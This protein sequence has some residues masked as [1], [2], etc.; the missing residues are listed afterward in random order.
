MRTLGL[1][2]GLAALVLAASVAPAA[3]GPAPEEGTAPP[4]GQPPGPPPGPQGGP[5]P[6]EGGWRPFRGSS[7]FRD[8][9][10]KEIEEILAFTA[11]HLPPVHA[12]LKKARESDPDRFRQMCRRLRFEIR[13][14]QGLRSWN[15]EAFRKAIEERLLETHIRELA[16]TYRKTDNAADRERLKR[17]LREA[18]QKRFEAELI[19]RRAQ[20]QHLE[21]ALKHIRQ[22]LADRE[23]RREEFIDRQLEETSNPPPKAE[24]PERGPG[25]RHERPPPPEGAKP[26]PPPEGGK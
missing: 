5:P 20:V 9:T 1:A 7:M 10:D 26:A 4:T 12:E 15:E 3:G 16:E 6:G 14:L 17:G 11:E 13:Q 25:E 18:I 2:A 24:T 22:E 8:A 21:G 19:A 23:S